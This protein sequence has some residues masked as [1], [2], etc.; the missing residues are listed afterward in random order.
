MANISI[1][2]V[3]KAPFLIFFNIDIRFIQ[4]KYILKSYIIIKVLFT[5]K[6]IKLIDKKKFIVIAMHENSEIFLLH[7]VALKTK[8]LILIF[9]IKEVQI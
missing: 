8:L 6:K 3:L 1:K 7:I 9:L 2:I 5:I 4:K